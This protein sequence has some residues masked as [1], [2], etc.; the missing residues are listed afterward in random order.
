MN[1]L[2]NA[3]TLA[4]KYKEESYDHEEAE[5]HVDSGSI[6]NFRDFYKMTLRNACKKA[7]IEVYGNRNVKMETPIYLLLSNSWNEALDYTK[8]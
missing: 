3:I 7:V 4:A 2:Q 6:V 8:E 1:K 5:K